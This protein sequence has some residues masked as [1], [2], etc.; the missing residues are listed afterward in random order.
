[1][2]KEMPL[3][4]LNQLHTR[5]VAL[6]DCGKYPEVVC[7]CVCVCEQECRTFV[8]YSRALQCDDGLGRNSQRDLADVF[9]TASLQVT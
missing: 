8:E 1:M 6:V 2:L 5:E 4:C 9:H 3:Q 7:V